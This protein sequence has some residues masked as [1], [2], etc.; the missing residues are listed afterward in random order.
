VFCLS[1][2]VLDKFGFKTDGALSNDLGAILDKDGD[3]QIRYWEFLRTVQNQDYS[4]ANTSGQSDGQTVTLLDDLSNAEN[5]LRMRNFLYLQDFQS[6]KE[7]FRQFDDDKDGKIEKKE[8][9]SA[10]EKVS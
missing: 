4:Y 3:G 10:L 8:F 7:V 9:A 2:L 1:S 5:L 6:M